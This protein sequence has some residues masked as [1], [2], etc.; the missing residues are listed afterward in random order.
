MAAAKGLRVDGDEA[1]AAP[2]FQYRRQFPAEID[3]IG[4]AGVHAQSACRRQLMD[5]VPREEDAALRIAVG[6]HA[7]PGPDAGTK[8]LNFKRPA[9]CAAQIRFAVN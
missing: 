1:V 5:G 2:S 8:P 4:N 9:K 7:S 3:R 6:D